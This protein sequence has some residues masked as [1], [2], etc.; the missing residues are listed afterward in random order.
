[1]KRVLENE[2]PKSLFSLYGPTE[3]SIL[4]HRVNFEDIVRG[5]IGISKPTVST[6]IAILD[7]NLSLTTEYLKRF[8]KKPWQIVDNGNTKALLADLWC[9]TLY[10]EHW[11]FRPDDKIWRLG[12]TL[13]QI[14]S[15]VLEARQLFKADTPLDSFAVIPSSCKRADEPTA[16]H[17]IGE[18]KKT[19]G[20]SRVPGEHMPV[21]GTDDVRRAL[22]D[23]P[24]LLNNPHEL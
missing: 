12:G 8:E 13:L 19:G 5:H 1:M 20:Y 2:P 14:A 21:N 3:G 9:Q 24:E 4:A 11:S 17:R 10:L 7:E 18:A 16:W 6:D 22:S 15:L 23:R